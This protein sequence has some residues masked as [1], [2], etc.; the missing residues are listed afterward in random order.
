MRTSQRQT[1]VA[2]EPVTVV[3]DG[4]ESV[5]QPDAFRVC[6]LGIQFYSPK[7]L[8]E[9]EILEFDISIPGKATAPARRSRAPESWSTAP[10]KDPPCYRIWVKFLDLP[11]AKSEPARMP[12]QER[13]NSYVPTART[14]DPGGLAWRFGHS[15][16]GQRAGHLP[17]P[18]Q[19]RRKRRR[20]VLTR[21]IMPQIIEDMLPTPRAPAL[22]AEARGGLLARGGRGRPL[23]RQ[24]LPEP[25][26][27]RR[28]HAPRQDEAS[29]PSRSCTCRPS[30]R[31]SPPRRAASS[32]PPARPAAASPPRWPR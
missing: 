19:P 24:R 26:P 20:A 5:T 28:G 30:S 1:S 29:R 6:P 7:P 23:P 21:E 8:P 15:P 27:A 4:D 12:V 3:L 17:G 25:R 22:R 18:R 10:E 13:L 9:F 16:E 2:R 32:W 14:S 31:I 11:E